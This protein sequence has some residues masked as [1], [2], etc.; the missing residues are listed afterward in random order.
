MNPPPILSTVTELE[1][2]GEWRNTTVLKYQIKRE[3]LHKIK[4]WIMPFI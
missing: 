4:H 2:E 3:H 1:T